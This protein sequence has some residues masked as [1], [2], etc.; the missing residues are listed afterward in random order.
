MTDHFAARQKAFNDFCKRSFAR[1]E[2]GEISVKEPI[3]KLDMA[4]QF[5][6]GLMYSRGMRKVSADQIAE[7]ITTFAPYLLLDEGDD[8]FWPRD[9]E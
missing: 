9:A 3:T 7:E 4:V 2:S 8:T 5:A 6:V 1:L